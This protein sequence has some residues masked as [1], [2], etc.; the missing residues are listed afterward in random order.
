MIS[1]ICIHT[2]ICAYMYTCIY[3][4]N[5]VIPFRVIMIATKTIIYPIKSTVP[6]MSTI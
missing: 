2:Y 4:L 5:E 3:C 1:H 6:D